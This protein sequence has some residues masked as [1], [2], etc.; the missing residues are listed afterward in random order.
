MII[1]ITNNSNG[2]SI[3]KARKIISK[4]LFQ[5]SSDSYCG[6]ISE[7]GLNLIVSDLKNIALKSLSIQIY[8][9]HKNKYLK[10]YHIGNNNNF[11]DDFY[12]F[13]TSEKQEKDLT[14]KLNK[15]E[16]IL[17][18]VTILAGLFHD[19]GKNTVKFQEK[20]K[21]KSV[22]K[23]DF[24]RHELISFI[25]LKKM[26]DLIFLKAKK[27]D[28]TFKRK[29]LND[30]YFFNFISKKENLEY[31]FNNIELTKNLTLQDIKN[32]Y[33]IEDSLFNNENI[34]KSSLFW[35]VLTHHK[36]SDNNLNSK[37][38]INKDM[39]NEI[40]ILNLLN[41]FK[42]DE[43]DLI[44][45]L[46][47]YDYNEF[48]NDD[49]L[50]KILITA[51]SINK[52]INSN[53][54]DSYDFSFVF[55]Y[56]VYLCRPVLINS[57]YMGSN[58]KEITSDYSAV[59][60]NTKNNLPADKLSTHLIKVAKYCEQ[61]FDLY[62]NNLK[63]TKDLH[64]LSLENVNNKV[65]E[66]LNI[67][68]DLFLGKTNNFRWQQDVVNKIL[69]HNQINPTFSVIIS[70]TGTGKTRAI[71]KIMTALN[72]NSVRYNLL[73]GLTTLTNQT[74]QEYIQI[75]LKK[76]VNCLIGGKLNES[77]KNNWSENGTFN[78]LNDNYNFDLIS[79]EKIS[80]IDNNNFYSQK[81]KNI[82]Q[83]PII[84]ATIDHFISHGSLSRG[85]STN[86]FIRTISSDLV[87]DEIDNYSNE[88][89]NMISR[90]I[91]LMGLNGKN[92]T[93]SSATTNNIIVENFI[94][95]YSY[96]LKQFYNL[97]GNIHQ[98]INLLFVSN[99]CAPTKIHTIDINDNSIKKYYSDFLM[100]HISNIQNKT[101]RHNLEIL[102]LPNDFELSNNIILENCLKL[103]TK[104]YEMIKGKKVSIG[105][106]KFNLVENTINFAK[107]LAENENDEDI[108]TFIF[109]YHS[110]FTLN[111]KEK[112]ETILSKLKRK[113]KSLGEIEYFKE[114]IEKTDKK[115]IVFIVST[116]PIIEVGRDH[117]YDWAI[118]DPST[119]EAIV[120]SIGRV[121]RHRLEEFLNNNILLLNNPISSIMNTKYKQY[122][123]TILNYN[124]IINNYDEKIF[125]NIQY[126]FNN[127]NKSE[128]NKNEITFL[129]NGF[130]K[131][132]LISNKYC[133]LF[134]DN[135]DENCLKSC[136]NIVQDI[137]INNN[138]FYNYIS[139][140]T[141]IISN[142]I[143]L[144]SNKFI[145]NLRFRSS[146]NKVIRLI[147][148][149]HFIDEEDQLILSNISVINNFEN[150]KKFVVNNFKFKN[151][152][153]NVFYQI[154][155]NKDD[156][157]FNLKYSN[158]FGLII[159]KK[160]KDIF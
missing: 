45:N 29:M 106:V 42:I 3:L 69:A 24:I 98:K 135:Y 113:N 75:G 156:E 36:L 155:I 80:F 31:L 34:L 7:A 138:K 123:K 120:Q 140:N 52:L 48:L 93:I 32:Y 97:K 146:Q 47:I 100:E 117:D 114:L 149:E 134:N 9:F 57:D 160:I 157:T 35:L 130:I 107:F 14:I 121:R 112:N 142:R 84:V 92:V 46:T 119:T 86:M 22:D 55:Y 19:L 139:Q 148:N 15:N 74:H 23:V 18:C 60:A 4:Y 61:N 40:N 102:K 12:S 76:Y 141:Y 28:E 151:N 78:D 11:S 30:R 38:I 95:I 72:K 50:C 44:K 71:P 136:E 90:L 6:K 33:Y 43:E 96:G 77:E 129:L 2:R 85:S 116:S 20:L 21:N 105:Y 150:N 13:K 62:H 145:G 64:S 111:D 27:E 144:M 118:I 82:L 10:L 1:L 37:T 83:K 88:Q 152:N 128:Y 63:L 115:N 26:E 81:E 125:K 56:I 132:R 108:E 154:N 79:N 124:S 110:K 87:L 49:Y 153:S 143:C 66:E 109:C 51:N 159:N 17:K 122:Y 91:F 137:Q 101:Q 41:E 70:E 103:H 68:E 16:Q 94:N 99:Y 73:L 127:I 53:S 25:L 58:D 126:S 59:L 39:F 133:L 8:K 54:S 158:L 67:N 104:N 147:N 131:E 65:I 5:I 89:L